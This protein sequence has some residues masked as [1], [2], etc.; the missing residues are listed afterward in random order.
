MHNSTRR[1]LITTT[2]F[3]AGLGLASTAFGLPCD[4]DM[5]DS[6]AKDGYSIVMPGPPEGAIA[7][8]NILSPMGWRAKY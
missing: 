2:C 3:V 5:A 8:P 6:Q 7:Q 4:I 1:L